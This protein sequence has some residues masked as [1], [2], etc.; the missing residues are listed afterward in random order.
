MSTHTSSK[1]PTTQLILAWGCAKATSNWA[2]IFRGG[3][4]ATPILHPCFPRGR[5]STS[6]PEHPFYIHFRSESGCK[7]DVERGVGKWRNIHHF[8]ST[9]PAKTDVKR[10]L[11]RGPEID[12]HFYIHFRTARKIDVQSCVHFAASSPQKGDKKRRKDALV[13]AP[14]PGFP[15]IV[16]TRYQLSCLWP[17][18]RL[19]SS[20]FLGLPY[21]ILCM[22][23]NKEPLWS[24]WVMPPEQ[25]AA[26]STFANT[27]WRKK[28]VHSPCSIN[29]SFLVLHRNGRWFH[30]SILQPF[31]A[32][33]GCCSV[34]EWASRGRNGDI[35]GVV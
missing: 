32:F 21:R 4:K 18:H 26:Q 16:A 24:L 7:M 33:R 9:L 25:M 1:P 17:A 12:V 31:C 28:M 8:T 11:G 6:I 30:T 14:K 15:F 23:H 19:H 27:S 13:T 2:S 34:H 5:K 3:T 29:T 22:N 10:M 35:Q 20:P